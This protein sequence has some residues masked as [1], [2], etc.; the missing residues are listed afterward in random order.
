MLCEKVFRYERGG[1]LTGGE[2]ESLVAFLGAALCS[3]SMMPFDFELTSAAEREQAGSC[4]KSR[5]PIPDFDDSSSS[6][7]I[8]AQQSNTVQSHS[9]SILSPTTLFHHT[10]P[11]MR[12]SQILMGGGGPKPGK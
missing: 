6:N 9:P 3:V 1:V 12:P 11:N 10:S 2:L 5:L 7:P 8:A 4:G